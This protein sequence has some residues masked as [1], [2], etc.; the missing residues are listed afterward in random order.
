MTVGISA[1]PR[2]VFRES[3]ALSQPMNN[4]D[5][6]SQLPSGSSNRDLQ[7]FIQRFFQWR[8]MRISTLILLSVVASVSVLCSS[9]FASTDSSI[10]ASGLGLKIA[11]FMRRSGWPDEV[12]VFILASLPV[13]ELRG[14]IPVGYWMQLQPFKI[15]VLAVLGNMVPIPFILLY[16]KRITDFVGKRSS[17]ASSFLQN[18]VER[19]RKK[20]GPIEEFQWL[21]LILFV[22]VPFPGTGA[23][24][25]AFAAT[26]LDMPFWD[27]LSANFFGVVFAGLL[28]NLLVNLGIKYAIAVGA[29]LFFVSTVMWS[30]LR[31]LRK[32]SNNIN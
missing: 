7:R 10:K 28:V 12:I 25:G 11:E 31:Y 1:P 2:I 4:V 21:G 13:L 14:A 19:T 27:A 3:Q 24:T 23:W 30:F 17:V 18:L 9:A 8:I 29:I 26:I 15:S 6:E 22:A 5:Y 20:A 32:P 16:L